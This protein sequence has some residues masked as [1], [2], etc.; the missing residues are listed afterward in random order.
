MCAT[1]TDLSAYSLHFYSQLQHFAP[2]SPLPRGFPPLSPVLCLLGRV[3]DHIPGQPF[4]RG[5]DE[6][7]VQDREG[8]PERG[9]D[10]QGHNGKGG[11]EGTLQRQVMD[12]Q[13]GPKVA[14][15]LC[16][17]RETRRWREI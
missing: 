1:L 15:H 12:I 16:L 10:N 11:S 8:I 3:S 4:E 5:E 17:K 14:L 6:G 9:L 13:G 7:R 2:P